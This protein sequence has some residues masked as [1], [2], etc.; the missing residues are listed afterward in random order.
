MRKA[1][2]KAMQWA[3]LLVGALA[4]ASVALAIAQQLAAM[5]PG[6]VPARVVRVD[7]VPYPLVVRLYRDPAI[8]G[9]TLP[10]AVAP[11]APTTDRLTYSAISVPGDDVDATEVRASLV[12]DPAVPNGARGTA[13]ITVRGPWTLLILVRGPAGVGTAYVPIRATVAGGLPPSLGW[14]I[15]LA[16]VV[17][18]VAFILARAR[19][20][21][22]R[23]AP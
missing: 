20:P 9:Y 11:Q 15:G 23:A 17:A 16:P 21:A 7:S 1:M 13:E 3:L 8:A 2:W 5:A 12:R 18:M 22:A 6:D 10:F 14:P 4:L 19:R